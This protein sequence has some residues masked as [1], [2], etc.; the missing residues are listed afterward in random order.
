MKPPDGS[1]DRLWLWFSVS[2]A[3]FLVVLAISPFKDYFREYHR[4]QNDHRALL[5]ERAGSRRELQEARAS[6]VG[7]RQIWIPQLHDTVD[8]CRT[9]HLGVDDPRMASE[10]QP[11]R[12]HPVVPHVP[13]DLQDF[14]CVVCHRGQGRA[15]SLAAAHGDTADWES[16]LLPV[17]YTEASCGRCHEGSSVPEA[18][19]LSRGRALMERAGCYGCH[20]LKGHETW[21]GDAP[22]LNGL[23]QKTHVGW[24]RA[25]LRD[26][27]ALRPG[28]WMPNFELPDEEIES[29]V[30]FLWAQPPAPEQTLED[31]EPHAGDYDRGR[32]LFRESRCISCH[33][34]EGKGNGSAP[35]LSGIASAVNRRWLLAF[36][37]DPHAFQPGTAMPQYAFERGD[38]VDLTQ[39][40][41]EEFVDPAAPEP[42]PPYRPALKRVEEGERVY[43]KYGCGGCH[44]IPGRSDSARI[45]PELNGIGDKPVALLDFGQRTDLPRALPDWLGAKIVSPRSFRSELKMP[46]FGMEPEDVQA[47]VTGLLACSAESLPDTYTVAGERPE[48][49]PQGRF[50]RLVRRYR[51]QSCHQIRGAGEDIA[52]APLTFE[53]SK[54]K[55]RWLEDYMLVPTTIRPLL[56][57]RMIPLRMPREE[58]AFVAE[59][60]QNVYVDDSIPDDLFLDGP[61]AERIERGRKLFHERHGC[62]AC[63]MVDNQGG[64][65][66]PLMNGLGDRLKPGWITW[67]LQGPRRWRGDVRCPDFGLERTDAEDLAAY[68]ASIAAATGS[69]GS[70]R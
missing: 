63:H 24:L 36:L 10:V 60:M 28:T 13:E 5:L 66:G 21:Q 30:A 40:M 46:V 34:V 42:G 22:D 47:V 45:G 49:R 38:L 20:E 54:V 15:T 37:R 44:A 12:T 11:H 4:Y 61:P 69:G 25:W 3:V 43:V 59:F 1:T 18:S 32:K 8:R 6:G 51:C 52:T 70:A 55:R 27:D 16:P 9:C 26:P 58:A 67:W 53:G 31:E 48:Y 33:L 56:T 57:D 2:S 65:Y 29:L 41:M 62:R 64:Y 14:G 17:R 35:E 7:I 50:G 19:L 39:Y 68:I 23:S